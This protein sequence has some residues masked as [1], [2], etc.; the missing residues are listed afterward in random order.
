LAYRLPRGGTRLI[1]QLALLA[2]MIGIF[3]GQVELMEILTPGDAYGNY[4]FGF[5]MIECW[6]GLVVLFTTLFRERAR[7]RRLASA[8]TIPTSHS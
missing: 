5:I 3:I 1:Y 7:S 6:G 8:A 4:F 2:G